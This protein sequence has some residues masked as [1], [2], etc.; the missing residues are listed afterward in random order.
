MS[1]IDLPGDA[2]VSPSPLHLKQ[3]GVRAPICVPGN[4]WGQHLWG[5]NA[6]LVL[7]PPCVWG[8]HIL[9]CLLGMLLSH[10]V[11][12]GSSAKLCTAN[13]GTHHR[14]PSTRVGE[15][16]Q[17][18]P[19]RCFSARSVPF[20]AVVSQP[21]CVPSPA[22]PPPRVTARSGSGLW[23]TEGGTAATRPEWHQS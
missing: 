16:T 18:V 1:P 17:D 23:R 21:P 14:D 7:P 2:A 13:S 8:G 6:F 12:P 4:P 19:S 10:L 20:Q 11:P 9:G 3:M 5:S 15:T 22:V